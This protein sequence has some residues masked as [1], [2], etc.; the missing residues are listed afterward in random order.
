MNPQAACPRWP[1]LS[2]P[3]GNSWL[4]NQL[5]GQHNLSTVAKTGGYSWYAS[6]VGTRKTTRAQIGRSPVHI[7]VGMIKEIV[8]FGTQEQLCPLVRQQQV[9]D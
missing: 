6:P 1:L 2:R 5:E 9:L 7:E 8:K 4:P 3:A